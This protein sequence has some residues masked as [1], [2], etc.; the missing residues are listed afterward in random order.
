MMQMFNNAN[1]LSVFFEVQEYEI[2][3]TLDKR[4]GKALGAGGRMESFDR[5]EFSAKHLM[6]PPAKGPATH[7]E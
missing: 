5:K 6:M 3:S 7:P 2:S 4:S 1:R